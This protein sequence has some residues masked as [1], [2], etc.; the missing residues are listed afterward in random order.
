ML[1]GAVMSREPDPIGDGLKVFAYI[2]VIVLI[3]V[4]LLIWA[5]TR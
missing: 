2:T 1:G 5:L 4:A 3:L